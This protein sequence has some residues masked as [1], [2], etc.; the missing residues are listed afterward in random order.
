MWSWRLLFTAMCSVQH[1][2]QHCNTLQHTATHNIGTCLIWIWRYWWIACGHYNTLQHTTTH[3]NNSLQRTAKWHIYLQNL[4]LSQ[5]QQHIATH[6][7]T[8]QHDSFTC[9]IWNRLRNALTHCNTL[10]HTTTHCNILHHDSFTC[11]IW[12]R[13]SSA[14]TLCATP[15]CFCIVCI[16]L[17][18]FDYVCHIY[19]IMLCVS[20]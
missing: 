2:A 10:Q 7:N 4:K 6:C 8:R 20:T 17:C 19:V 11:K 18:V 1:I 13:P 15:L 16:L 3:C 5:Q 12:H 9:R 14:P